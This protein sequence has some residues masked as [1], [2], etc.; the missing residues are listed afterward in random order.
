MLGCAYSICSYGQISVSYTILSGSPCTPSCIIIIII[1]IIYFRVIFKA[2]FKLFF[3]L[4]SE[5][6]QFNLGDLLNIPAD[7]MCFGMDDF[8]S[9]FPF[10]RDPFPG[11]WKPY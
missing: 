7:F 11:V 8:D 10:P 5:W 1:I 2:N 6:Q 3:T 9:F 4:K